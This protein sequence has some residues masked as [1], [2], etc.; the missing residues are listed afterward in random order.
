VN[1]ENAVCVRLLDD[2]SVWQI[3]P[4]GSL[5]PMKD[6]TDWERLANMTEEEIEANALSDP[7]NPPMTEEELA[8]MMRVPQAKA[9]RE[10][11]GLTQEEF[12]HRFHIPLQTI[13]TWEEGPYWLD[14]T[15]MLLL[16][17]IDTHPEAVLDAFAQYGDETLTPEQ[18]DTTPP[19]TRRYRAA[20]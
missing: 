13:R 7:D 19:A 14:S 18:N 4:D 9:I 2:G 17:V 12:A 15:G 1:D 5:V 10:R 20:G 16:R 3:M 6:E 8:R 11:L